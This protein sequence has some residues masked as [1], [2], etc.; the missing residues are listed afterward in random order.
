MKS[1]KLQVAGYKLALADNLKPATSNN[2]QILIPSPFH[3]ASHLGYWQ[4]IKKGVYAV[5]I[6]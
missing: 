3:F 2:N 6:D 4:E 5:P 1:V